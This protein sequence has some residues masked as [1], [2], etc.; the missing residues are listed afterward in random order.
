MAVAKSKYLIEIELVDGKAQARLNGVSVSLSEVDKQLKNVR[1]STD[2]TTTAT[3]QLTEAQKKQVDKSGLAG[4]TLVE[5]GRTIS[6]LPFGITAITN[7]LSQL[8]TLFTTLIAS[9]GGVGNAFQILGRQIKGPLGIIL[10][11]Q[12]VIALL[13]TFAQRARAAKRGTESLSKSLDELSAK[14]VVIDS[15]VNSLETLNLTEKERI[16]ATQELIKLVPTLK[17]EDF[18]YGNGLDIVREKINRYILTQAARIEI[19]NLVRENSKILALQ[20]KIE[21]INLIKDEEERFKAITKLLKE[22]GVALTTA[23]ETT[24]IGQISPALREQTTDEIKNTFESFSNEVEEEA[25]PIIERINSLTA[26]IVS[27]GEIDDEESS[28]RI[29]SARRKRAKQLKGFLEDDFTML[30]IIEAQMLGITVEQLRIRKQAQEELVEVGKKGL[31]EF[32]DFSKE[33]LERQRMIA[34]ATEV[35]EQMK[36][37]TAFRTVDSIR[38]ISSILESLAGENKALQIAT[39]IAEKAS[40][41]GEVIINTR[42]SNASIR[43]TTAALGLFNPAMFGVGRALIASNNIGS[44]IDIAAI[45]AQAAA[46]ISAIKSGSGSGRAGGSGGGDITFEAPDFNIVGASTQSQLAQTIAET[47]AKPVR[48]F[49]VGKDITT[50]QEL[51]RNTTRTASFG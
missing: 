47:E 30:E 43:A 29:K 28:G 5:L 45:V 10:G 20:G 34:M 14:V 41:I 48:A 51:D 46:S 24:L 37:D 50:Q 39:I 8:A 21:N 18:A 13:E 32:D 40:A 7:N 33:F 23:R 16:V 3:K 25:K 42:S 38:S 1:R 35:V 12:I 11:F 31:K 2:I 44:A 49:V 27:G 19:D 22:E 15:Y 17:K 36:I 6:D 26:T 4:A 9:T